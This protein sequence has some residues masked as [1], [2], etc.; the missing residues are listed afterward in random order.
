[1]TQA[2]QGFGFVEFGSEEDAEYAIRILNGVKLYGRA[3]RMNK[4]EILLDRAD[5][6]LIDIDRC[7]DRCTL[8]LGV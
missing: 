8:V 6:L 2:H 7:T 4:V 3:L 5:A 1:M